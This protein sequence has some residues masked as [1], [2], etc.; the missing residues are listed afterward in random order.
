MAEDANRQPCKY[1]SH[2]IRESTSSVL[3]AQV[4]RDSSV[5]AKGGQCV[6]VRARRRGVAGGRRSAGDDAGGRRGVAD[7]AASRGQPRARVR[8]VP[9]L[10]SAG[11][12]KRSVQ[13]GHMRLDLGHRVLSLSL[14][15]R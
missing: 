1:C 12:H 11:D 4:P 8:G 5:P 3:A 9:T 13:H 15:V 6:R 7:R 10:Q 2:T 14:L